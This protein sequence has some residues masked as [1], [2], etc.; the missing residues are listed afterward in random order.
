ML[1]SP[2]DDLLHVEKRERLR[3]L[4][5]C[6]KVLASQVEVALFQLNADVLAP[7]LHGYVTF[8]TDAAER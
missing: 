6:R 5:R 3:F 8:R 4:D 1:W 2:L 7:V